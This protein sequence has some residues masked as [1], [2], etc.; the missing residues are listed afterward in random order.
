MVC[1]LWSEPPGAPVSRVELSFPFLISGRLS[2][3]GPEF[4]KN[5]YVFGFRGG[6][7]GNSNFNRSY[8][9]LLKNGYGKF[10]PTF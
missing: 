9:Q 1:L 8:S 3:H 2:G 5:G 7:D 10:F 6:V 4:G